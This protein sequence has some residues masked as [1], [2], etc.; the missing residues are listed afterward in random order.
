MPLTIESKDE[1]R[2][3]YRG[4]IKILRANGV[5]FRESLLCNVDLNVGIC[6]HICDVVKLVKCIEDF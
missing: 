2:F 5:F 3:D 4:E 1:L 6:V